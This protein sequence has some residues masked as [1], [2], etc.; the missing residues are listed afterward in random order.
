MEGLEKYLGVELR[1]PACP[2]LPETFMVLAL[3]VQNAED[4][5]VPG[6]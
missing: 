5:L 3:R 4:P 1:G 6:N 2:D